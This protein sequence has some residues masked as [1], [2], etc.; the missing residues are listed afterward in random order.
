[1]E[2]YQNEPYFIQ[3]IWTHDGYHKNP[4]SLAKSKGWIS[5]KN[6]HILKISY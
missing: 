5:I 1:M 2:I 3:K 6:L 4:Q